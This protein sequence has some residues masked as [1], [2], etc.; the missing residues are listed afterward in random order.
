MVSIRLRQTGGTFTL[1]PLLAHSPDTQ[2]SV[3]NQ[4]THSTSAADAA[5]DSASAADAADDSASSAEGR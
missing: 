2:D 3:G 4:P 5:A 1:G